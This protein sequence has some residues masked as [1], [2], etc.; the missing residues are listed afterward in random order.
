MKNAVVVEA[1]RTAIGSFGGALST[2][3]A[4]KLGAVVLA[5]VLRRAHVQPNEVED[6]ILGQIL[7]AGLGQHPARQAALAAGL[8]QSST[9][10]S[11]NKMCGSG[12]QAIVLA[13]QAVRAGEVEVVLAG[14]MENMSQAP[15]LLD[16]ARF[17]YRLGHG[18]LIDTMLR[19]GLW[20]VYNDCH[21]GIT[22]ENVAG[23]YGIS[24]E[25]Q[26]AFAARSQQQCVEAW[27]QG[28][29]DDEIVPVEV[30]QRKKEPLVFRKDEYPRPETTAAILARLKPAF[31]KD[32]VVTAG[33]AS[34]INDGAAAALIMS[35]EAAARRGLKPMAV[36]RS[37]ATAGVDP[38]FMGMG[39]APAIRKALSKAGL[40]LEQMD[41]IEINE[42]FAA[43][44]L[45]VLKELGADESRLN[46]NG[47]A[48]ALGHPVG[49]SGA[50]IAATLLHAMKRRQARF[51]LA[52]LCIGG[53]E[54]IA[55]VFER[56]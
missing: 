4:P 12:L 24:R 21:M 6:V 22:A 39:P 8:P 45:A 3:A 5:E 55:A 54:G 34:G 28:L 23:K 14:G 31:K 51:G 48:I 35:D 16:Q 36:I 10:W 42:A 38:A 49:A 33:N 18:T 29:F 40:K 25:A 11:V 7:Q 30:P 53:G 47:G 17:G 27:R 26:D 1:C 46:V 13:A 2:V 41:A 9:A 43:Q 56:V 37:W 32:G 19:D 50:R 44:V 20:D 15:F 52:S